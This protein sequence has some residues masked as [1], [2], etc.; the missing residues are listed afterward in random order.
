[1]RTAIIIPCYNEEKRLPVK[2]FLSFAEDNDDVLFL[3]VNDGS[4][5]KTSVILEELSSRNESF[6]TIHLK[7]NQGKAEAVRQGILHA[8]EHFDTDCL[9]YWDADL[10]TPLPEIKNFVD[11]LSS[12]RYQM[13]IGCRLMRLGAKI[14]RKALR[15]YPG[16]IFATAASIAL[17]L[18]VYDTQ[19][20][21][22][23]FKADIALSLFEN[24]FISR[25][26]FDVEL[27]ARYVRIYGLEKAAHDI[28][29]YPLSFWE[30]VDGSSIKVKD[31]FEAPMELWKIKRTYL[32]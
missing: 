9:G 12:A 18:Q 8:L 7:E 29:E 2:E 20:G 17:Q 23:L 15:H 19:C 32:K 1:M 3:F 22:K 31:F 16:R 14:K 30:D 24:P 27:L 6:S 4:R 25:L 28:Y 13:V 11:Y 26:L 5:D 21:A 10:A